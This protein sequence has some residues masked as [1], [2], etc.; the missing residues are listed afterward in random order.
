MILSTTILNSSCVFLVTYSFSFGWRFGVASR[1]I[2]RLYYWTAPIFKFPL[3]NTQQSTYVHPATGCRFS[4]DLSF[5]SP[6]LSLDYLWE[7][8]NDLYGSGHFPILITST[9]NPPQASQHWKLNKGNGESFEDQCQTHINLS[10][11][12]I[13]HSV[14]TDT[15]INI[16]IT[17]IPKTYIV[18]KGPVFPRQLL[19]N[20]NLQG[21]SK[22]MVVCRMIFINKVTEFD[23]S[24]WNTRDFCL[25]TG[26]SPRGRLEWTCPPH[27]YQRSFLRL[28][29]IRWVLT[30]EEGRWGL[31][32][33]EFAKYG[34]WSKF[35]ASV[36]HQK[37][38]C[39]QLQGGG[40]LSP[41]WL[42]DQGLCPWTPLG[43]PP[44]T[45]YRLA[46]RALAV[47][48]HPTFFDLV[49]PLFAGQ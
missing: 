39:F 17:C 48:V 41:T 14:D 22:W 45:R 44:R 8:L 13:I 33:R 19:G 2:I 23:F 26:A 12:D 42:P 15:L 29:Q 1:K 21:Y 5:C 7:P 3:L 38:K 37:L 31:R 10:N 32:Y 18:F 6:S 11:T 4:I 46:L 24:R 9:L 25:P 36:G 27:F 49:T 30:R 35:A 28:M 20:Q 43:A 47:R 34:Q 40:A 16:A